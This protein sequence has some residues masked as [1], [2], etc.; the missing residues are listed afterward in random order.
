[1][2]RIIN[3]TLATIQDT[4]D[5]IKYLLPFV[6]TVLAVLAVSFVIW[7]D[8]DWIL[9]HLLV[10]AAFALGVVCA[11]GIGFMIG[12]DKGILQG[13]ASAYRQL[14]GVKKRSVWDQPRDY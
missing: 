10:I 3:Y 14:D 5:F 9:E 7:T 12:H 4:L 8:H 1:M 11:G 6:L 13:R 2:K